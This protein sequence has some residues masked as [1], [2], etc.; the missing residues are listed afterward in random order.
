[1]N[2]KRLIILSVAGTFIIAACAPEAVQ[3]TPT[4]EPAVEEAVEP[5]VEPAVEE[6]VEPAAEPAIEEAVEPAPESEEETAEPE[7]GEDP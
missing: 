3:T 2:I 4:P 5:A 7:T 6:A 1:M